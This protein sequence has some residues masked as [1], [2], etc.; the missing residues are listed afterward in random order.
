MRDDSS[1]RFRPGGI[2]YDEG[3]R[4]TLKLYLT[5][6]IHRLAKTQYFTMNFPLR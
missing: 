1:L 6:T 2:D 5:L 4:I 3:K